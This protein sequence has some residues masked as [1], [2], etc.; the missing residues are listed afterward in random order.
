MTLAKTEVKLIGK[1]GVC[2][3]EQLHHRR[4]RHTDQAVVIR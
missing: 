4:L 1:D 3:A 2:L